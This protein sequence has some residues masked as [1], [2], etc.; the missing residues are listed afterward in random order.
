MQ[1]TSC[2]INTD[3]EFASTIGRKLLLEC[4][5]LFAQHE[6]GARKRLAYRGK[7]LV[8]DAGILSL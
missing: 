2:R 3:A 1:R 6:L 4:S 8:A 5:N 7:N